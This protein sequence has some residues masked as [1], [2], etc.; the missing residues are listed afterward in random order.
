MNEITKNPRTENEYPLV[1]IITA[2]FNAASSLSKAIESL[3]NQTYSNIEYI[4]IDGGSNDGVQTYLEQN[5]DIINHYISEHEGGVADAWNKGLSCA[6]GELIGLLNTDDCYHPTAVE[7]AV[8]CYLNNPNNIIY[9]ECWFINDSGVV[10]SNHVR[11]EP[12]RLWK[13]LGFVPTTCFVPTKVYHK[14]GTFDISRSIAIEKDFLLRAHLQNI[15]FVQGK[16][17]V[18]MS[19]GGI[20]YRKAKAAYFEYLDC[21]FT[22][23]LISPL[24]NRRLQLMY[25]LSYPF[26][27]IRKSLRLRMTAR[28]FKH[29]LSYLF[30]L[31][32]HL[33]PSFALKNALLRRYGFRIGKQSYILRG[34]A[35]YWLGNLTIGDHVVVNRNCL[36]DNRGKLSIGNN[37]SIAHGSKIYTAGHDYN[38]PYNDMFTAD[39]TIGDNVILFSNVL[40]QPGVKIG[41]GAVI[42]PGSVVTRDVES[43]GVYGGVPACKISERKSL[44]CYKNQYPFWFAL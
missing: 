2:C 3:R 12:S 36:L 42:L 44:L 5:G 31:G 37:V 18:Y 29:W 4:V 14:V 40:V 22:Y 43:Y 33:A 20:S 21:L 19:L 16:H 39:V 10:G 41:E 28:K 32:Y 25:R 17:R 35:F 13:G 26:R 1:T 27:N 11:F 9:G 7:K 15:S 34:C 30:I 6:K 23:K 24:Q 38:S 8:A